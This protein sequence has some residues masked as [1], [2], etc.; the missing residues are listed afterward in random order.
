MKEEYM[1]KQLLSFHDKVYRVDDKTG[2]IQRVDFTDINNTLEAKELIA[3][4]ARLSADK[5][6][7]PD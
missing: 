1:P 4:L 2:D 3:H 6:T 7:L 5:L